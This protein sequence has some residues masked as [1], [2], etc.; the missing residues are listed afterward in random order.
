MNITEELAIYIEDSEAKVAFVAQELYA[1]IA[2]LHQ[3][4]NLQHMIVV[5]YSDYLA[6]EYDLQ[7]PP[8]VLAP[9]QPFEGDAIYWREAI[10]A[11]LEPGPHLVGAEVYLTMLSVSF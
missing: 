8:E 3:Y 9:F 2:P 10:S 1:Q 7:I 5:A 4:T 6:K 11:G